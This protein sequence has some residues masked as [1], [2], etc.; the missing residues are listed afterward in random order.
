MFG[1]IKKVFFTAMTYFGFNPLGVNSLEYVSMSNHE[2]KA[3]PKIID[4]NRN[5]PALYPYS[6][7]ISKCSGTFGSINN[8]YAKLCVSDVVKNINVKSIQF[9][10]EN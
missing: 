6:V 5:E 1:F 3:R 4:V 2:C 8:P 7:K 10:V 9:N